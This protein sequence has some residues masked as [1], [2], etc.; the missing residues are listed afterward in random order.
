MCLEMNEEISVT[1]SLFM[2]LVIDKSIHIIGC[3]CMVT[4]SKHACAFAMFTG[5][6]YEEDYL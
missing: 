4:F 6:R 2:T 1:T 3:L 5:R